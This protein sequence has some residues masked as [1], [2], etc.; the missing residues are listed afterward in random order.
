MTTVVFS[1]RYRHGRTEFRPG[2]VY[3]FEDPDAPPFFIA[4]GF[5]KASTKPAEVTIPL[6]ELDVDPC[7]VWGQGSSGP[8][9]KFVMP[10]RAAEALGISLEEAQAFTWSGVG[11]IHRGLFGKA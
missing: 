3:G 11:T 8:P 5:A 4:T 7:T 2:E 1:Q 10:E 9:R 6:A